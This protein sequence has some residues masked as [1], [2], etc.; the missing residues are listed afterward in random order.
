MIG[1]LGKKLGMTQIFDAEG[2]QIPITA[3]QVGPCYVTNIRTK[4]KNGY[5]AVQLG[6]DE[7]KEKRLSKPR[8]GQFKKTKC[9][10]LRFV[11]E[12][13][14]EETE[15]LE[16]G[17]QIAVDMFEAGDFVDISGTSIGKGFQGVVKRHHFK[18]AQTKSHGSKHGRESGSIGQSSFPSRVI[19]GLKMAG[20]MGNERITVQNLKV[21]NV[22]AE[23]QVITIEGAVPGIEGGYLIIQKALKKKRPP[24]KW[25]LQGSSEESSKEAPEEAEEKAAPEAS[26]ESEAPQE[27][28]SE[29][30]E[31][32]ADEKA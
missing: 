22:D 3:L 32:V 16:V 5:S 4:E 9:P 31:K 17:K 23:S 6:F 7:I 25:K 18:G 10:A 2:K 27:Q 1:L 19:K 15:G 29:K 13:R 12:I 24:K 11:R 8:L 30:K 21:R 26:Q 28:Q 20:Q 14:T